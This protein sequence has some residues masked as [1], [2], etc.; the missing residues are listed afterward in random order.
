MLL[1]ADTSPLI[2]LIL[3]GRLGLL[4]SLYPHFIIPSAVYRELS[5]HNELRLFVNELESLKAHVR[6]VDPSQLVSIQSIDEGEKEAIALYQQ[7]HAGLLLID[8]KRQ[9]MSHNP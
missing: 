1:V 2:S 3:I 9:G 6:T 7:L 4:D 8:D 5:A